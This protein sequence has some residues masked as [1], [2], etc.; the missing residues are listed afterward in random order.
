MPPLTYVFPH[1]TL[2]NTLVSLY[3]E[4]QNTFVPVLHRPTLERGI[5]E[6]RHLKDE[7]FGTIVLLVCA[8]GSRWSTERTVLLGVGDDEGRLTAQ[9]Y[10]TRTGPDG[11]PN[12]PESVQDDFWREGEDDEEWHS[13]GWKW[14]RQIRF[15]KRALYK[16]PN[17]IDVQAA[18]VRDVL[19]RPVWGLLLTFLGAEACG[20]V[21]ARIIDPGG[22]SLDYRSGIEASTRYGCA[23]EEVI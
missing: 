23:Q 21:P 1:S 19:L 8:L 7:D 12:L 18:C 3:F 16:P 22:V 15:G 9:D 4:I 2:L 10:A 20:D 6:G 17:L 11:I 13:A 14:F 5:K